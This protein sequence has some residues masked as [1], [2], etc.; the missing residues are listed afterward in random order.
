MNLMSD[1]SI[2]FGNKLS[3]I[4]LCGEVKIRLQQGDTVLLAIFIAQLPANELSKY[5][6]ELICDRS[7]DMSVLRV[8]VQWVVHRG[9]LRVSLLG[10]LWSGVVHSGDS[11]VRC[12]TASL[13]A[14]V[15]PELAVQ[16]EHQL[17]AQH[18]TPATV[19]LANDPDI[20]VRYSVL[21][22]LAELVH[23]CG[24]GS[25]TDKALLQFRSYF[26]EHI[27]TDEASAY[28]LSTAII[29]IV[30]HCDQQ[31]REDALLPVLFNLSRLAAEHGHL[32]V[33]TSVL[34]AYATILECK[35]TSQALTGIMLPGLRTLLSLSDARPNEFHPDAVIALIREIERRTL[36]T[37]TGVTS[38][39]PL[40]SALQH[41]MSRM[42]SSRPTT[43]LQQMFRKK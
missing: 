5:L 13:L 9:E 32:A 7:I 26:A 4:R 11:A 10:A 42:F 19:T 37:M 22:V 16:G 39:Q 8:A 38:P 23:H 17:L 30:P 1:L 14:A 6:G 35:A 3:E 34:D 41:G 12:V 33:G 18:V 21:A 2:I 43:N 25:V 31:Y 15:I 36:P 40:A 27:P 20:G 24:P 28:E 29:R